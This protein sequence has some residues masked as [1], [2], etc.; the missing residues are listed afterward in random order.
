MIEGKNVIGPGAKQF[1]KKE[2]NT[3]LDMS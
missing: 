1:V 3:E 2:L